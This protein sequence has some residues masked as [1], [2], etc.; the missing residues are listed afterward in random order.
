MPPVSN[1]NMW[2]IFDHGGKKPKTTKAHSHAATKK[3]F[4]MTFFQ[5]LHELNAYILDFPPLPQ[6]VLQCRILFSVQLRLILYHLWTKLMTAFSAYLNTGDKI[7]YAVVYKTIMTNLHEAFD[8]IE[9]GEP[10]VLS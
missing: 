10:E 8:T 3:L 5:L 9:T 1:H 2:K 6:T 4:K 7:M